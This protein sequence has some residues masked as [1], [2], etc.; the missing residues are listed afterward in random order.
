[1]LGI[2][3]TYTDSAV[4]NGTTYWYTIKAVNAVGQSAPSNERS[5]KPN[6]TRTR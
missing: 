5:A 3:F 1:M 4:V 2:Q 6:V